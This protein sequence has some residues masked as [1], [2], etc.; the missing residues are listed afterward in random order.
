MMELGKSHWRTWEDGIGKEWLLTNGIGGYASST[1]T[2]SNTRR[3]HGLLIASLRPPVNRHLILSKL[4][5]SVE[6]GNKSYDISSFS[7]GGVVK[8]GDNYLQRFIYDSLPTFIYSIGDVTIRKTVCMVYGENTVIVHYHIISGKSGLKLKLTP[9]VNFRDHHGDS[10]RHHMVFKQEPCDN[11]TLILP[12]GLELLIELGCRGSHYTPLNDCWFE[13][14]EYAVE[15]ERGLSSRE[16]QYIPGYFELDVGRRQEKHITFH[17]T[18]EKTGRT[19]DGLAVIREEEERIRAL[20]KKAGYADELASALVAAADKFIVYRQSTD[21]KTI[22]AGYPWFTDW[23]RDTMISL[24]GLTLSTKRFEDAQS[25]LYTFSRYVRHGL[26]PNMFPDEGQEPGYNSVDAALWYFEAVNKFITYT[27]DFEFVKEN[28]YSS[29]KE[30]YQAFFK[31]TLFDIRM[32]SDFLISA[33]NQDTQLTWMDAKVG[34]WAVTPRQGKA[35]EINALWYNALRTLEM[36]ANRF[37]QNGSAYGEAA[38]K[39]K[40]AFLR[41]FWNEGGACL[42]DVV[43]GERTDDSIR[44]NQIIAASLSYPVIEGEMAKSV[45]DRVWEEL[46]TSYGLRTLSQLSSQYKGVYIGDQYYRDSAYHQGTV[47]TW[48]LGHFITAFSRVYGKEGVNRDIMASFFKPFLD[49]LADAC[50]GNISEIF[51]GDEPLFPRG[52][53]AQAWSV[54]EILR[55]YTEDFL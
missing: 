46:Y 49:H 25:I 19:F 28:L 12:Y 3:Y 52:C 7:A 10:R 23:G 29:L 36:L 27:G 8:K 38:L 41:T 22:L 14:M 44:P 48:P 55:S 4:E 31:G 6:I 24:C 32:D 47:W 40:E 13:N 53:F 39:A 16:D 33:G 45:V 51:D 26:I 15:Q 20:I 18:V 37:D 50:L 9:L 42:Y 1:V 21:A 54:A 34:S 17:A 5:E 43:E 2:G 11:R 30:I 35:V